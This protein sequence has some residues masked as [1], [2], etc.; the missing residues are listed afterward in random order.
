ML[1]TRCLEDGSGGTLEV[2][3]LPG[4][5]ITDGQRGNTQ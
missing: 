2:W 5:S 4:D 1:M 3:N